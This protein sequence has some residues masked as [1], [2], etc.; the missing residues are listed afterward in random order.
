MIAST[1]EYSYLVT[2]VA[3]IMAYHDVIYAEKAICNMVL[4]PGGHQHGIIAPYDVRK[5]RIKPVVEKVVDSI[6]LTIVNSGHA[7][8]GLP[9]ELQH[10]C[11]H[12]SG[13]EVFAATIATVQRHNSPSLVL[14]TNVL[15]A[16]IAL[17]LLSHWNGILEVVVKGK[18]VYVR[19]LGHDTDQR[20]MT[21][22]VGNI[23]DPDSN[24]HKYGINAR[25][26]V[27]LD[28]KGKFDRVSGNWR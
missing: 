28:N 1:P 20:K 13:Y 5:T 24:E 9:K 22:L 6:A 18:S 12:A 14:S 17:W 25:I 26:E 15:Y 7:L 4:D 27:S 8:E 19:V 16:E 11:P 3:A 10:I 21:V 23:C 2:T